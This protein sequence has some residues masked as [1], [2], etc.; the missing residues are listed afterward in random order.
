MMSRKVARSP[1]YDFDFSFLKKYLLESYMKIF[2]KINLLIYFHIS[3][4]NDLKVI[5]DLY[6]QCL[7]QTLSKTSS[8]C[9]TEGVWI[10]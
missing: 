5:H 9:N 4:P 2:V 1:K 10:N 8:N 6:S 7:A 3:K